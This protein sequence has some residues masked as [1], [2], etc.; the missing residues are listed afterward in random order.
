LK[1]DLMMKPTE[2]TV[3]ERGTNDRTPWYRSRRLFLEG[4]FIPLEEIIQE[5]DRLKA[6]RI[7]ETISQTWIGEFGRGYFQQGIWMDADLTRF[8]SRLF[9]P[10]DRRSYPYFPFQCRYKTVCLSSI[11]L[12]PDGRS[13]MLPGLDHALEFLLP[14]MDDIQAGLKGSTF[15]DDMPLFRELKGRVPL[16]WYA[17][18]QSLR[19]ET[20]LNEQDLKEFRIEN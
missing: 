18:W 7:R 14:V 12:S 6:F 9:L 16:A 15:S 11:A 1:I 5:G 8:F 20:Y 4:T 2:S 13:S 3:V 10:P 17:P 19:V